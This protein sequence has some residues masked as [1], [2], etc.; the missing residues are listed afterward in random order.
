MSEP[1]VTPADRIAIFVWHH[2]DEMQPYCRPT[3]Q[4]ASLIDAA[5]HMSSLT[6]AALRLAPQSKMQM[7]EPAVTP[8][9]RI[10]IF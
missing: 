7:S 3:Q 8:A 9:D 4:K 1:A 6:N 2:S 5:R 10:A